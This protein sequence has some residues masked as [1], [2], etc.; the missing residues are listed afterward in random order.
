MT[1]IDIIWQRSS[2]ESTSYHN[3]IIMKESAED[4]YEID[5][6]MFLGRNSPPVKEKNTNNNNNVNDSQN[7]D[8]EKNNT[9]TDNTTNTSK[10]KILLF[11]FSFFRWSS[12]KPEQEVNSQA[13]GS[14]N[15][16]TVSQS[17]SEQPIRGVEELIVKN[18]TKNSS[19][20]LLNENSESEMRH[21]RKLLKIDD[22]VRQELSGDM[23]SWSPDKTFSSVSCAGYENDDED[24]DIEATK[25]IKAKRAIENTIDKIRFTLPSHSLKLV[26]DKTPQIK[27]DSSIE[28]TMTSTNEMSSSDISMDEP[29]NKPVVSVSE[30]SKNT[31][32]SS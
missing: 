14:T 3:S 6:K 31:R 29:E 23:F 13:H 17:I 8:D 26:R 12:K 7:D 28:L 4:H 21:Q 19:L 22:K 25:N 10:S 2:E 11:C 18:L 1:E 30:T 32:S 27:P 15:E 20:T 24:D 16:F 5:K 9:N